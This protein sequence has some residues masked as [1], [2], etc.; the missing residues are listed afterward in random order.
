MKKLVLLSTTAAMLFFS[1]C[2]TSS[3]QVRYINHE[4]AGTSAPVSL[5]LDYEDINRAAQK[6]VNSMLKSPYLDRMYRIKMRK[7]GKPLVL[8]ISDFTNDTTQRLDIDQIVK[9][10]RIALLNSGKFIVTTALR[11]GGPE[12]RAT[13]E[14]R[15]LRKNKEF[16]QKTIAKQGT[17]IAPDLSLSGKII[18]RTTPLPNGEQR[19]DY[20]IQMSLTDVTS[21]LAFWEGEE[22]ISKAGSSKAAPW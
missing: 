17:V 15:K 19:V 12:D 3:S 5:G 21:G 10:I 2:A 9:K 8:M 16:N 7:E 6:L 4:K 22:V 14:L 1:G 18:Q 11:A 13:M 20:Y